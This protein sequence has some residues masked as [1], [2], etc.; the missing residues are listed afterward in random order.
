MTRLLAPAILSLLVILFNWKLV[1]TTEFT[2]L[3]GVDLV[4]QVMPWMQYQAG[5]WH[6][7][8][9]PLWDPTSWYGQSLI[10]QA[11]PG[12]AYPLNWLLFWSTLR[13]TLS[14]SIRD[15]SGG[16]MTQELFVV[17]NLPQVDDKLGRFTLTRGVAVVSSSAR[18]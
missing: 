13:R 16:L 12:V 2:W 9:I 4:N 1:L 6:K 17:T 18:V 15:S 3:E 10:G 8:R 7:W 14:S 11:Q 5:D